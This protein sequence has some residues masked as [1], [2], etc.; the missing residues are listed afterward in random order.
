MLIAIVLIAIVC[1]IWQILS[2]VSLLMLLVLQCKSL[3]PVSPTYHNLDQ[4]QYLHRTF[5]EILSM[6]SY[7]LLKNKWEFYLKSFSEKEEKALVHYSQTDLHI[8]FFKETD[9][10]TW[11][12]FLLLELFLSEEKPCRDRLKT[13]T[14]RNRFEL[15]LL[16][17]VALAQKLLCM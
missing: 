8:W 13:T 1:I 12:N 2:L 3:T 17:C 7:V 6:L 16:F 4:P 9:H 11:E 10:A 15:L 14:T 5:S